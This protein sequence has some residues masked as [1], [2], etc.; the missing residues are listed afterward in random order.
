M[1][2]FSPSLLAACGIGV[3]LAFLFF[4]VLALIMAV[5]LLVLLGV[6]GL[7]LSYFL[8]KEGE[9]LSNCLSTIL[10]VTLFSLLFSLFTSIIANAV[11]DS[12]NEA[13]LKILENLN[14]DE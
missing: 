8:S 7:M 11:I 5:I 10:G 12:D 9:R 14:D 4:C 3:L 1:E 13:G 2:L 6:P